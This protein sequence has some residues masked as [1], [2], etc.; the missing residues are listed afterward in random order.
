MVW[1]W[2]CFVPAAEDNGDGP[3]IE[4]PTRFKHHSGVEQRVYP[5]PRPPGPPAPSTHTTNSTL[6]LHLLYCIQSAV[7]KL[8]QS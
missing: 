3:T 2:R 4:L 7:L 8:G 1:E 5:P 6:L